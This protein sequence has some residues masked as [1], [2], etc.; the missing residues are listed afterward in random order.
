[1]SLFLPPSDPLLNEE[2]CEVC[3]CTIASDEIQGII[4]KMY[5]IAFG[6]T[7]D[8][9]RAI[10]VGLAAPQIGIDKSIILVDTAATGVF[11]K[12]SGPPPPKMKEFINPEILW[13]SEEQVYWREGCYST[14]NLCGIVPR[15]QKVVI[16]A[17]DRQGNIFTEEYEGYVARIFQ[18]ELDHLNGIRFPDRIKDDS[19]LHWVTEKDLP[20]YRIEWR[21][22]S[23]KAT[24]A[25]W[26]RMRDGL[27]D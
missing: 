14:G 3:P 7:Q 6:E 15:S 5:D 23:Q 17:Y 4:D 18:H 19:D 9:S 27:S 13:K 26:I 24:R 10:M 16:R 20:Q 12:D 11:T 25:D 8:R 2:T 1:M 22:W 21:D